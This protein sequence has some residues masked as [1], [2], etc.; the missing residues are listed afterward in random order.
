VLVAGADAVAVDSLC[1][2]ALGI[3][4]EKVP[5]IRFAAERGYGSPDWQAAGVAGDGVDALRGVRMKPSI[6]R[7]LQQIPEPLFRLLT[8]FT[9]CRPWI[10]QPRCVRCGICAGICPVKA[11]PKAADGRVGP[12]LGEKCILCMCCVESCPKHAVEVRSPLMRLI[13]FRGWLKQKLGRKS[14]EESA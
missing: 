4:P 1:C 8:R 5:M 11:I 6:A 2:L 13:R 12:V 10:D 9:R 7:R 14:N 3:A